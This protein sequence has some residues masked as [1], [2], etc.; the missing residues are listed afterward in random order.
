MDTIVL[1]FGSSVL[2]D[3]SCMQKLLQVVKENS[4]IF[5]NIVIV[6]SAFGNTTD[7]LFSMLKEVDTH[8]C[9][10][11]SDM[12]LAVGERISASLVAIYLKK[13][14]VGAISFTGSQT[15]IITDDDHTQAKIL[16]VR[17]ERLKS[18]LKEGKVV[19]VA[20]F[21]GVSRNKEVTTLGRGGS[22]T[23][24]VALALALDA[25]GVIF[26]KDV[27]GLFDKD[28]KKESGAKWLQKASYDEAF[29]ILKKSCHPILHL[30]AL[31]LAKESQIPIWIREFKVHGKESCICQRVLR[32]NKTYETTGGDVCPIS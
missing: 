3:L 14:G 15:G 16:E 2:K 29:N 17:A 30:R 19:V 32:E 10:R 8:A 18:S 22:D 20:G 23:S 6:V 7:T 25:Y 11:E 31:L 24:A 12:L 26:Y 13:Y 5:K 28:P 1:K 21:Q 4:V 27:C 9:K